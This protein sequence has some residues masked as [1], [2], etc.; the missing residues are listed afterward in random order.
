MPFSWLLR[1]EVQTAETSTSW[2]RCSNCAFTSIEDRA[3]TTGSLLTAQALF[4]ATWKTPRTIGELPTLICS[5]DYI[6]AALQLLCTR[7]TI[8]FALLPS[9]FTLHRNWQRQ[10]TFNHVREWHTAAKLNTDGSQH[11]GPWV[12]FN[13]KWFPNIS[14]AGPG[15]ICRKHGTRFLAL[16]ESPRLECGDG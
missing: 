11:P 9:D 5:F 13:T 1:H 8:K 3:S 16:S 2:R 15:R 7:H 10:K 6:I 4:R 14:L 12:E